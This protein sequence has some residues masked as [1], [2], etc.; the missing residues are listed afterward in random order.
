MRC[1]GQ[2]QIGSRLPG[3]GASR[4]RPIEQRGN[5]GNEGGGRARCQSAGGS[6]GQTQA[7]FDQQRGEDGVVVALMVTIVVVAAV[8]IGGREAVMSIRVMMVGVMHMNR[9]CRQVIARVAANALL[10]RPGELERDEQHQEDGEQA[11]HGGTF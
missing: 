8:K 3:L 6:F 9:Q 5:A 1:A 4:G 2:R 11:A 7:G 10:R